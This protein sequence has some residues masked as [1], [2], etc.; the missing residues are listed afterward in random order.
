M[1]LWARIKSWF[2]DNP[3]NYKSS[4]LYYARRRG[5]TIKELCDKH[6]VYPSLV[7]TRMRLGWSIK[8]ALTTPVRGKKQ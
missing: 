2:I 6:G 8:R 5:M 3:E 7:R 1:G 4:L